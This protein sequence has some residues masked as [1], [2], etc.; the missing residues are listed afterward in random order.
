VPRVRR[1]LRKV[2]LTRGMIG[3]VITSVDAETPRMLE[4]LVGP[5]RGSADDAVPMQA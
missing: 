5:A 2:L 1:R 4:G 3:T